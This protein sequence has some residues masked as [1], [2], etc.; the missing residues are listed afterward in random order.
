M[1]GARTNMDPDEALRHLRIW[2]DQVIGYSELAAESE[3]AAA[4][5][6]QALDQWMSNGGHKPGPWAG[7]P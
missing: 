6:F 1:T 5:H 7:R 4:E 2:A 3:V